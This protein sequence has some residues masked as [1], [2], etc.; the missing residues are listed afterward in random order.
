MC[1]IIGIITTHKRTLI[2]NVISSLRDLEYRGYDSAGVGFIADGHIKTYKCL[3]APSE[4]LHA[5][6]I[7]AKTKLTDRKIT[8]I[9]GHNRWATHGKPSIKNAHPHVDCTERIALV[10]NGTILNFETLK[11]DLE[12]NG[13]HFVSDT[14]TE[15]IA[16][17][18]EEALKHHDSFAEAFLAALGIRPHEN[19]WGHGVSMPKFC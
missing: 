1:G 10:H 11:A 4:N 18:I 17:A 7:Y 13:H 9:I 5:E 16:H 19:A 2:P 12:K 15:V 6:D 8:T 3:G 14:D